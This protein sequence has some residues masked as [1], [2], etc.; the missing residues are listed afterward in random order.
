VK[1]EFWH[2]GLEPERDRL[3]HAIAQLPE[4][5]ITYEQY[6]WVAG[7][8]LGR[9]MGVHLLVVSCRMTSSSSVIRR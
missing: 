3:P 9:Q 2:P 8:W 6:Q 5:P 1:Q 7:R 4:G